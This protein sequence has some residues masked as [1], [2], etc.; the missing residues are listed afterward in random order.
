MKNKYA[1]GHIVKF[2]K[3]Y[4]KLDNYIFQK[5]PLGVILNKYKSEISIDEDVD[6]KKLYGFL[7]NELRSMKKDRDALVEIIVKYLLDSNKEMVDAL[8]DYLKK[9]IEE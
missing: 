1:G 7:L 4:S 3:L 6:G 9:K 2:F 5:R 8:T